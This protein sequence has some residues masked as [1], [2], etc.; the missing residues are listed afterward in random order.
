M[1]FVGA[2]IILTELFW[3]YYGVKWYLRRVTCHWGLAVVSRSRWG[4]AAD[5]LAKDSSADHDQEK[6]KRILIPEKLEWE[7]NIFGNV[8]I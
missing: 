5:L 4:T 7:I 8:I 1:P 2:A 3:L 6:K